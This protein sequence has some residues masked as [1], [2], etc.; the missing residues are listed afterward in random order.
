MFNKNKITLETRENK[1]EKIKKKGF[2][3]A[4]FSTV[5]SMGVLFGCAGMLVGCGEAGP[6]GDTGATGPAGPQGVAGSSFL[7]DEGVP[8]NTYGANGDVYL[9]TTTFNLYK[10]VE[11]VWTELGNIKGGQG[12]PGPEGPQGPQGEPGAPAIAP[13]VEINDDGYWVIN[14]VETD[15]KAQGEQG[16]A[17]TTPTVEINDDGYWVINGKVSQ[18][19]AEA[20][21]GT[22]G[23]DGNTWT[24]G[25]TEPTEAFENDMFLNNTTW[26]VYK[27]NGTEWELVGN[28]KGATGETGATGPAGSVWLTGTAITG[29]NSGISATITNARVGDLYLN[30]N[31]CDLYQCVSENTWNWLVN[32]KGEKGETGETG[33]Q[34]ETG[35]S[36]Y[37][38]YDGYL[39]ED[40]TRSKHQLVEIV[41][42]NGVLENTL[43]LK[44][45]KF[46]TEG[47]VDTTTNQVALMSNYFEYTG[48]V[49]YSNT[50]IKQIQVYANTAG[51][52]TIGTATLTDIQE[53]KK[54]GGTLTL[55]NS[56]TVDVIEGLNTIELTLNVGDY[57]TVVIG[58]GETTV[59]L[60][61]TSGVDV[62]DQHG[63]YS[64]ISSAANTETFAST[65]GIKDKLII[66]TAIETTKYIELSE[67]Y[68][69]QF[70]DL[71]KY[72]VGVPASNGS[73]PWFQ[74]KCSGEDNPYENTTITRIDIAI[75]KVNAIDN[76][77][78]VKVGILDKSQLVADQK[79]T[80][81]REIILKLPYEEIKNAE[82]D[83]TL[84][85]WV[86]FTGLNIEMGKNDTLGVGG[87]SASDNTVTLMCASI[88]GSAG[89]WASKC[90]SNT[91]VVHENYEMFY[92]A[93][94][95]VETTVDQHLANLK[96]DED[97]ILQ[98]LAVLSGKK[99]S[100][101]GDS[102]STYD[103]YSNNANI[104]STIGSNGTAW[105]GSVNNLSVEETWWMQTINDLD[106]ELCVNNSKSGSQVW[107]DNNSAGYNTRVENLHDNTGDDSGT[108]PNIIF[109]YMGINDILNDTNHTSNLGTYEAIDFS[110]LITDDGDGTYT[111]A[112]P[113]TFAEA[114]AITV[115]KA[116]NLYGADV[117]CFTPQNAVST[118]QKPYLATMVDIITKVASYFECSLVDLYNNSG[119][120][121]VHPNAEGMD[122]I[123]ELVKEAL[124]RKFVS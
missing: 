19:K 37:L 106:M 16:E 91:N 60:A 35:T 119:I 5:M 21:D 63:L 92:T 6:K 30:T 67:G 34:G 75:G 57:E 50:T 116:I 85:K 13:T 38:G 69:E 99:V 105:Y 12:E 36:V 94:T 84:K 96:A 28:I 43:E 64:L 39:W 124:V 9:D 40:E 53:I 45:N 2:K 90:S 71:S 77:Q 112:S 18:V 74:Y 115:H 73:S 104:N 32:I 98:Q 8:A 78:K 27:Y 22:K 11:G 61:K 59:K 4:L 29:T 82:A 109:I 68:R 120:T 117:F 110:A 113:T 3:K 80:L 56:T 108:N 66:N 83:G 101:L 25:T 97:V 23:A 100:I 93:Y 15:Q 44:N 88:A 47:L 14:G 103:G 26:N 48:K 46:F 17:G 79:A 72:A 114:Y 123:T 49:G 7:T 111:Y 31:T 118:E 20:I 52:L 24:V 55:N 70:E 81:S 122:T 51:K 89:T 58:G 65:N 121:A 10:K 87:T 102:I 95:S 1:L 76:N 62:D 33:E 86:S 41:G 54:T 107:E 42:V